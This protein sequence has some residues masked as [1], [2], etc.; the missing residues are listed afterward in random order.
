MLCS[1]SIK[2]YF[3]VIKSVD[4]EVVAQNQAINKT[5]GP[6]PSPSWDWQL[7]VQELGQAAQI[8]SL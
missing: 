6:V 8:Y 7:G 5:S 3:S 1:D 4:E 2:S